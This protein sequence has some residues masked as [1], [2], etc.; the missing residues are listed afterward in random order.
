VNGR[1]LAPRALSGLA[2]IL[3][4]LLVAVLVGAPVAPSGASGRQLSLQERVQRTATPVTGPLRRA[5]QP[6][7]V[8]V[9]RGG[10]GTTS[11][12]RR[13]SSTAPDDALL[14]RALAATTR[15]GAAGP[16]Q[17][18]AVLAPLAVLLALMLSRPT[19]GRRAPAPI[20]RTLGLS[21][22]RAPPRFA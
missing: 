13:A 1:P 5:P 19:R 6:A 11:P 18:L 20:S 22:P 12:H 21:R 3:T 9:A 14:I 8:R 7:G 17:L 4:S 15:T 10:I 16:S 2:A